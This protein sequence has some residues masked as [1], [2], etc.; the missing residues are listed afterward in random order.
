MTK[1]TILTEEEIFKNNLYNFNS[2]DSLNNFLNEVVVKYEPYWKF[3]ASVIMRRAEK[4]YLEGK[5]L[6]SVL[7]NAHCEISRLVNHSYIS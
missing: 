3:S 7:V 2:I 1:K 4:E 5:D 6:T